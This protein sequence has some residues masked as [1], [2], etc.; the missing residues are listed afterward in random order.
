MFLCALVASYRTQKVDSNVF[1]F[2]IANTWKQNKANTTFESHLSAQ[3][4]PFY[5]DCQDRVLEL[6]TFEYMKQ[7]SSQ[8][9]VPALWTTCVPA[10]FP[11]ASSLLAPLLHGGSPHT[12]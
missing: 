2:Q 9:V 5:I 3:E 4:L 7:G 11:T 12:W 6:G 10:A 8:N 1:I